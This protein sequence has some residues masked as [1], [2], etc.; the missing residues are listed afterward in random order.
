MKMKILLTFVSL[1]AVIALAGLDSKVGD[2]EKAQPA[3]VPESKIT[4]PAPGPSRA[5]DLPIIGY[6]EKQGKVITIKSGPKGTVY[7]AKTTEGKV[8]FE[9]ISAEQMRAQAPELHE[10]I[11]NAVAAN[12]GSDARVRAPK[13]DASIGR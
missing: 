4:T 12:S 2:G 9:N 1:G 3:K 13:I 6:L 7:S 10:F 5:A 8:L 11:K